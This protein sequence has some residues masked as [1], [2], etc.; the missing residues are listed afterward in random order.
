MISFYLDDK[1]SREMSEAKEYVSISYKQH[2]QKRLLLCNLTE[3]Y[4]IFQE[5]FHN[6]KVGF[7]K[8]CACCPKWSKTI[9]SSRSHSVWACAIHQNT[10]L[11][12]YASNLDYKDLINSVVYTN[13][14][15]LC[16]VNHYPNSP[17][18]DNLI[19]LFQIMQIMK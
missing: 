1:F 4:A 19:K 9:G 11:A 15:K 5:K 8:F 13:T 16:M 3:L 17:R 18:K 10:I 6:S 2:K 12:C 7:S 14:N